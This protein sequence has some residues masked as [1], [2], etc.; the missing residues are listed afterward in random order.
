MTS[1]SRPATPDLD[2][3]RTNEAPIHFVGGDL[4]IFKAKKK[5]EKKEKKKSDVAIDKKLVVVAAKSRIGC[6]R[7]TR[8]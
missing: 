5:R 8:G 2:S 7:E 1:L 3:V 4:S 6:D